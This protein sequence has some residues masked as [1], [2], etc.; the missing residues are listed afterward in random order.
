MK[1][2]IVFIL[3][4]ATMMCAGCV[5]KE[6]VDTM[7]S[8][9]PTSAPTDPVRPTDSGDSTVPAL[10]ADPDGVK[11]LPEYVPGS[12]VLEDQRSDD[13]DFERKYRIAYYRIWG[14]YMDLLDDEEQADLGEWFNQ[15]GEQTNH[16]EFQEEMLLVSVIKRYNITREE[17]DAATAKYVENWYSEESANWE[18]YEIPNGDIIYTF[19]NEIINYYYRYE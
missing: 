18:E 11:V 9:E 5:D 4:L 10:P 17:F 14:E 13:Y 6:P 16:G 3:L 8:T 19:D 15:N 1:R 12:I 7:P 2:L